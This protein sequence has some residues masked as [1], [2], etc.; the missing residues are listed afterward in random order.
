MKRGST[1]VW[2]FKLEWRAAIGNAKAKGKI[3]EG[4]H[5]EISMA[6]SNLF[7]LEGEECQNIQR[8]R[9]NKDANYGAD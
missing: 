6:C 5:I 4:N 7:H 3:L 2:L 1:E 8:K 9:R